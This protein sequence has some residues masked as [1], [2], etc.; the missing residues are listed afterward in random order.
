MSQGS[1][2]LGC[3]FQ[4]HGK[5]EASDAVVTALASHQGVLGSPVSRPSSTKTNISK[6]QLYPEHTDTSET[7]SSV[8]LFFFFFLPFFS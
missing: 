7:N 2:L 6:F 1:H 8:E 5:N 4:S 3:Q